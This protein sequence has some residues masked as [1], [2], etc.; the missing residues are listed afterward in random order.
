VLIKDPFCGLCEP[1]YGSMSVG[2]TVLS[3][4][5]KT[6]N[7]LMVSTDQISVSRPSVTPVTNR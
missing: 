3:V 4:T 1:L 2:A 6:K 5:T 7:Y